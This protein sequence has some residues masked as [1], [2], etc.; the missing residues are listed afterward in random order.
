MIMILGSLPSR[1]K[2]PRL[3]KHLVVLVVFEAC[4]GDSFG[5]GL[6]LVNPVLKLEPAFAILLTQPLTSGCFGE[7][8]VRLVAEARA[9]DQMRSF[10]ITVEEHV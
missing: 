9:A 8:A 7:K 6:V 3:E 1:T 4:V 10:R 5:I 2:F